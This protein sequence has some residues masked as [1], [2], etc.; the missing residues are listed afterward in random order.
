MSIS[1]TSI[2]QLP[3]SRPVLV[4]ECGQQVRPRHPR[5]TQTFPHVDLRNLGNIRTLVLFDG[6]RVVMSNPNSGTPPFAIGGVDLS[7]LPQTVDPADRRGDG[8]RLCWPGARTRWRAWSIS[9]STRPSPA[10]RATSP[11]GDSYKD[12]HR[13]SERPSFFVGTD[14]L[15]GRGHVELAGSTV[16]SPDA[17]LQQNRDWFRGAP[18]IVPSASLGSRM[19]QLMSPCT[20]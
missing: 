20:A 13:R 15:G 9:S 19:R 4:A 1:A 8:R 3:C 6:Q 18:Q 5:A 12:D 7:T 2:R 16:W 14:V 11:L 10:S 17:V